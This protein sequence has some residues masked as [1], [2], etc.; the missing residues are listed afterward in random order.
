M[1]PRKLDVATKVAVEISGLLM[2][3]RSARSTSHQS[4]IA[5][6]LTASGRWCVRGWRKWGRGAEMRWRGFGGVLYESRVACEILPTKP[7]TWPRDALRLSE[8]LAGYEPESTKQGSVRTLFV[9]WRALRECGWPTPK[10][11]RLMRHHLREGVDAGRY[12][13]SSPSWVSSRIAP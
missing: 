13:E 7:P 4:A 9:T 5:P 8:R 11:C 2:E 1:N 12:F 10:S 6:G 3:E